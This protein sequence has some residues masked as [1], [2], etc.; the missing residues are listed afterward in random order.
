MTIFRPLLVH[1][2]GPKWGSKRGPKRYCHRM[3]M[4]QKRKMGKS[5]WG[6]SRVPSSGNPKT[7]PFRVPPFGALNRYLE[8]ERNG[9]LRRPL[10][11]P[12]D[13]PPMAYPIHPGE[14]P[15]KGD[16]QDGLFW[17][18]L[19]VQLD[20][21]NGRFDPPNSIAIAEIVVKIVFLT[22]PKWL[23][24]GWIYGRASSKCPKM[25]VSGP[26]PH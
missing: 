8:G 21:P 24:W 18:I 5:L 26:E 9:P 25:G 19:G 13:V 1:I 12:T 23:F 10:L 2:W 16:H 4:V 17:S 6:R 11:S 22:P 20:L 7:P 15:Q 3:I 14:H